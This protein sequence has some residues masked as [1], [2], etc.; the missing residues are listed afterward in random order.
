MAALARPP[1]LPLVDAGSIGTERWVAARLSVR[2]LRSLRLASLHVLGLASL[3][4]WAQARGLRVWGWV[5]WLAVLVVGTC[6]AL[7]IAYGLLEHRWDRQTK[8][9]VHSPRVVVQVARTAWDDVRAGL[10]CALAAASV[11]SWA[12]SGL[13]RPLPAWLVGPLTLPAAGLA[14]TLLL[15]EMI[16]G[17]LRLEAGT[18]R[19]VVTAEVLEVKRQGRPRRIA[20]QRLDDAS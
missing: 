20:G 18:F 2:H 16:R 17:A 11:P 13:G 10:W 5:A 9:Q 4:L 12:A 19:R 15:T 8:R 14:A 6:L 7:A 1:G 3:P